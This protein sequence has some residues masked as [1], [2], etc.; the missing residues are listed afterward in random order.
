VTDA[1]YTPDGERYVPTGLTRGPWDP[2]AQHGGPPAALCVREIER[3]PSVVPMQ[4]ARLTIELFRP[5]PLTPLTLR[6]EIVRDGKRLQ[7]VD[8]S[9]EADGLEVARARGLRIR[10]TDTTTIGP[11]ATNDVWDEP[12]PSPE[13]GWVF[14]ARGEKV[15]GFYRAIEHRRFDKR[16]GHRREAWMR[17][18]VS[19]VA[20][21]EPSPVQRLAAVADAGSGISVP[22]DFRAVLQ[23]NAEL[24]L[25]VL[26][27][28]E[29]PWIGLAARTI[30]G[31]GGVGQSDTILFDQSGRVGSSLQS[32]L[33]E[34][35]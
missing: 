27:E 16:T 25:H 2:Q 23:I 5:V 14:G 31:T 15:D 17:L 30:L 3:C 22:L 10:A 35:R 11:V 8:V 7:V 20:G 12:P 33:V 1:L 13:S 26:R 24:T 4:L 29:G 6:H 18:L 32:L 34:A 19:V 28:P 9:V 21:E